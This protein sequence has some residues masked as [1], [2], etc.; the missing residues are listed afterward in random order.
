MLNKKKTAKDI[1]YR[2]RQIVNKRYLKHIEY[3][4]E[5]YDIPRNLLLAIYLMESNFRPFLYR[6]AE[7]SMTSLGGVNNIIL[8]KPLKNY[9]IGICQIGLAAIL[10]FNGESVYKHVRY[11]QAISRKDFVNI[12][13]SIY[14]KNNLEICA[15]MLSGLYKRSF[16]VSENYKLRLRYIGEE[17]NGRYSYGLFLEEVV[18]LLDAQE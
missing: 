3:L 6:V 13:K 15:Q 4:A 10:K 9:T 1:V 16:S 5:T 18:N 14:Y 17:Y 11:I 2:K 12:I 8:N 7:Y